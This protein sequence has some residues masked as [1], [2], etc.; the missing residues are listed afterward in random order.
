MLLRFPDSVLP[1][2]SQAVLFPSST[3]SWPSLFWSYSQQVF[4]SVSGCFTEF[5]STKTIS[6]PSEC[7]A[8]GFSD[9]PS[10]EGNPPPNFPTAI[11]K[12]IHWPFWDSHLLELT[13][14]HIISISIFFLLYRCWIYM[15]H[16]SDY[17]TCF[18]ESDS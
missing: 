7:L 6:I 13:R 5:W 10:I 3:L 18:T 8:T 14:Y 1:F 11:L 4:L 9:L 15:D 2:H 12:F 17:I 16:I